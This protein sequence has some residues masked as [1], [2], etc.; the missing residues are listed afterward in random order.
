MSASDPEYVIRTYRWLNEIF[1]FKT[2]IMLF[3]CGAP[4]YWAGRT[5]EH[6]S[7]TARIKDAWKQL[8]GPQILLPCPTCLDMFHRHMPELPVI[9]LW[10]LMAQQ[11][12]FPLKKDK[13]SVAIF[14]PC[15]SRYVPE[16]QESIRKLTR[17]AGFEIQ[18]LSI[19]GKTATCCGYGGLIYSV[20]PALTEQVRKKRRLVES[21]GLCD[22]LHQLPGYLRNAFQTSLPHLDLLLFNGED[23]KYRR[24]P[25]L[26]ERRANRIKVKKTLMK[27]IMNVV[28][29]VRLED[30][31]NL[32]VMISP[33]LTEKMNRDLIHEDNVKRVIYYGETTKNKITDPDKGVCYCHQLQGIMTYWVEY[34]PTLDG[35]ILLN[36]Y[37]HRMKIDEIRPSD[38]WRES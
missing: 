1:P 2:A 6:K 14:D 22:V 32:R 19:H 4:A 37:K 5:D 3:C 30:Y 18:E 11:G 29:D 26:T 31:Q 21:P 23:R 13:G 15:S 28:F 7:V 9:S 38:T 24:A 25:S 10:D 33:D 35:I 20:N 27:E 12:R 16:T 34:R 17:C 8:G 36:I